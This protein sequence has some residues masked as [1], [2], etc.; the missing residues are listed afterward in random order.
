MIVI[1]LNDISLSFG[2]TTILEKISFSL[3]ESDKLGIVGVNGCGKSSLF[4]IITGEIEPSEGGVFISKDKTIGILTQD[5][6]LDISPEGGDSP[7]EQ[8]YSAFPAL[9][10]AEARLSE[11]ERLMQRKDFSQNQLSALAAE[12]ATLNERFIAD[13]GLEFRGRSF[14]ILEK[15]G[16]DA[17]SA[18]RPLSTLSGGQRTRLALCRQLSREPDILLLDEP[19]NHLDIETLGWLENFLSSYRKCLLIISHDR[20]FLDRVTNKTLAIEHCRAKLYSGGYTRSME[21]REF[22]RRV[23]EKHYREQQREIARQE[24]YI[25]QQRAWNRE[26]NIIAAESRQKLLDK[27]EKLE[28]PKEAPRPVR[29]KFTKAA[30]SGNDVLTAESLSGGYGEKV[31]FSDVNFLIKKGERVFI[32]GPNGCGKSTLLRIILGIIEPLAGRI[33]AGYNVDIGYYDQANQN[34]TDENTVL[35]ELWNAYPTLPEASIRNTLGLFRFTQDDVSKSVAILSGGERARLTLAKLILSHMNFLILDEPTN[36]LDIDS[37]EALERALS[38]FDGTVLVVSHDRY[39]I[40]KLATRILDMKPGAGLEGDIL[41]FRISQIGDGFAEL[42][43]EKERRAALGSAEESRCR[44]VISSNKEAYLRNKKAL[45]DERRKA[46]RMERLALEAAELEAE[47]ERLDAELYGSAA[48]DYKRAA[49]IDL[50]K[51]EIED[52]LMEIYEEIGV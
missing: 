19:T 25:A 3:D 43:R 42:C 44:E 40:N 7:L 37:R 33:E 6:A 4:K 46:R 9:L 13:G 8:M 48:S 22:D 18:G 50:C 36:H 1:S 39:L 38:E 30:S 12:Y 28:R 17:E 52:R 51:N 26:R 49:E 47:L 24:A 27:M 35:D 20:Y 34:L 15:M 5:G 29:I 10:A 41:D 21:Q 32:T 2:T 16:F 14:S 45:A 31:L 11:L 23:Y